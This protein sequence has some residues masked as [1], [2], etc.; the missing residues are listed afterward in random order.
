MQRCQCW[1]LSNGRLARVSGHKKINLLTPSVLAAPHIRRHPARCRH[2]RGLGDKLRRLLETRA[3]VNQ[4]RSGAVALIEPFPTKREELFRL[5]QFCA[6]E[7]SALSPKMHPAAASLC[8][9]AD[10]AARRCMSAMPCAR[11]TDRVP[12]ISH[13]F[14]I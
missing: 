6:V 8:R 4:G 7:T 3:Y 9:C 2:L 11:R 1:Y 5:V 14:M 10:P 12:G 13:A